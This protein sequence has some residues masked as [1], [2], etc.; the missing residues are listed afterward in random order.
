MTW[1][2]EE[3]E[4]RVVIEAIRR[5][6]NALCRLAANGST[7]ET[8]AANIDRICVTCAPEPKPD[9]FVVD[10]YLCAAHAIGADALL[11]VNK[12]DLPSGKRLEEID[13]YCKAG[14][15]A[16][17]TSAI[18]QHGIDELSTHLTGGIALLVGQ[19]G[20]GKSSL[21]NQ[22][23]PDAEAAT[24]NLSKASK[25]GT[26]T[27]TASLMHALPSGG[28]LIDSPGVR[29]FVPAI[30][31][32]TTIAEGF[33]EIAARADNCRFTDCRH[34]QEPGCAVVRAVD[35]GDISPRRYESYR[36]LLRT[37]ERWQP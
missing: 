34:L 15:A 21:L 8:L 11:V 23:V 5:R 12:A 16:V 25:E 22:L 4:D 32:G 3:G 31:A 13:V 35:T 14:Y 24:A 33:R 19:S 37:V 29:D 7:G 9:W 30:G 27:T 2:R 28:R 18:E 6:R 1:E 17:A 36:R 26:H 10:R 20:V